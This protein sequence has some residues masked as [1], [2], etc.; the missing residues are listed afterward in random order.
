MHVFC[1][2]TPLGNRICQNLRNLTRYF[3]P[4]SACSVN[5]KPC[6]DQWPVFTMYTYDKRM[7]ESVQGVN[8]SSK[9]IQSRKAKHIATHGKKRRNKDRSCK[10]W[11][12]GSC[13]SVCLFSI[14]SVESWPVTTTACVRMYVS[15]T[16]V[17][18]P[19]RTRYIQMNNQLTGPDYPQL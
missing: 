11:W 3:I 8:L 19:N 9:R 17:C 18:V 12:Y 13:L 1:R 7:A 14:Q 2:A 15:I 16:I 6:A 10:R 5:L 4:A